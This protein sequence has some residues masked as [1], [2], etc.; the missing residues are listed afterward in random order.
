VTFSPRV[1]VS[2]TRPVDVDAQ[3]RQLRSALQT[4]ERERDEYRKLFEAAQQEIERLRRHL[5]G[6]RREKVDTAQTQLAFASISQ[7]LT[8]LLGSDAQP[9]AE[10][11]QPPVEPQAGTR[12]RTRDEGTHASRGRRPLPE[13]LPVERIELPSPMIDAQWTRIGE[14]I[15]ETLEWRPASFVRVH[16]VRGKFARRGDASQGIRIAPL[17]A[18]VIDKGVA[19]PGLLAHVL[20]SKYADHLPLHRQSMIFARQGIPL[21]RSTLGGW[22][23]G[24]ACAL[25]PLVE[26]MWRRA[27]AC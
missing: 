19:G 1:I 9:D 23:E 7:L 26:A 21:A 3:T 13:H 17:P 2:T 6:P 20:V 27:L 24:A 4:C 15:T 16:W 14:E 8:G 18:R 11:E 25:R 22:V 10:G 5:F 12:E